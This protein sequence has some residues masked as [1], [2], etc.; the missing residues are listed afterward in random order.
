MRARC[1]VADRY[2]PTVS[3]HIFVSHSPSDRWYAVQLAAYLADAGISVAG[4]R[5]GGGTGVDPAEAIATSAGVV[6]VLTPRSVVSETV[7]ADISRASDVQKPVLPLLLEPCPQEL[8][9][10][11]AHAREDVGG[12]LMPGQAFV[13]R[14]IALAGPTTAGPP[15]IP[16][17]S[18]T[19][20]R[21]ATYAPTQPKRPGPVPLECAA[22]SVTDVSAPT[23]RLVDS[24]PAPRR[25]LG[26][27]LSAIT[28]VVAAAGLVWT[29]ANQ[30][31]R[32]AEG[33]PEARAT[34]AT[35]PAAAVNAFVSA[36]AVRDEAA[37]ATY[38]CQRYQ[39]VP[40]YASDFYAPNFIQAKVV[41]VAAERDSATANLE[42]KF[43]LERESRIKGVQYSVVAEDGVWKVC[44]PA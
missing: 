25:R 29:L 23:E 12:G 11:I 13:A 31:P 20:E 35:S 32:S 16:A 17:D 28:G 3:G 41:L 15:G 8:P 26:G 42:L 19:A 27:I 14:L 21:I 18:T 10:L 6:V 7:R 9:G 44:G 1:P 36:A 39:G 38:V 5:L 30:L 37:V 40:W 22:V 4:D 33:S 34:P 24:A 2:C 43:Q